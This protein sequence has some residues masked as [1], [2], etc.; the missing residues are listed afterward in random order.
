MAGAPLDD[1]FDI[2]AALLDDPDPPQ[3]AEDGDGG[4]EVAAAL[5]NAAPEAPPPEPQQ[6]LGF[7]RRSPAHAA[8]MRKCLELQK[9]QKQNE[10]LKDDLAVLNE[11]LV[12][13]SQTVCVRAS[14]NNKLPHTSAG[15]ATN[16]GGKCALA[17]TYERTHAGII[18]TSECR[19]PAKH[20]PSMDARTCMIRHSM[21]HARPFSSELCLDIPFRE[22]ELLSVKFVK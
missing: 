22:W 8:Y 16:L 2:A 15:R 20:A 3:G 18:R 11:R 21:P 4:F 10:Q 1:D 12:V 9:T 14:F 7:A 13:L 6:R 19:G 17:V 5:L